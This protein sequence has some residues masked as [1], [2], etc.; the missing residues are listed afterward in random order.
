MLFYVFNTI[1]AGMNIFGGV[2]QTA[3]TTPSACIT[4]CRN[5]SATCLAADFNSADNTCWFHNSTLAC[6]TLNAK[7]TCTNF[8]ITNTCAGTSNI[9]K[10]I[11]Y[12]I[13]EMCK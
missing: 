9:I 3:L 8:K 6:G 1:V 2:Q 5:N 4:N 11:S 10:W 13:F 7:S 12:L